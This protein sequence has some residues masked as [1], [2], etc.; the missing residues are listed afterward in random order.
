MPEYFWTQITLIH[1]LYNLQKA[2]YDD[3]FGPWK[4]IWISLPKIFDMLLA[5]KLYYTIYGHPI[6]CCFN[7][8]LGNTAYFKT[9]S[10]RYQEFIIW[11]SGDTLSPIVFL[12]ALWWAWL[13]WVAVSYLMVCKQC[14]NYYIILWSKVDG[15]WDAFKMRYLSGN[16]STWGG[17][18]FD[19]VSFQYEVVT[20]QLEEVG[21]LF[22]MR[23][24]FQ[25]EMTL[26]WGGA[27][28]TWRGRITFQHEVVTFNIRWL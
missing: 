18:F 4:C 11:T 6:S 27:F 23:C 13:N 5:V 7:W 19:E 16:F 8:H 25:H 3:V 21:Y 10:R 17:A 12:L 28:T 26:T 14:Q 22:N 1:L 20:L 24:D 15:I 2:S 9:F